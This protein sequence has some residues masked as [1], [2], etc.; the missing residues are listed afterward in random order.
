MSRMIIDTNI[1]YSL[2]GLSPN[3]KVIN[4]PIDQFKLSITTPSLIEVIS[5]YHNDLDSIKKCISPIINESI[6]LISIGHAPISNGFLYRL[7]FANKIDEVKDIIDN[8][9]T[10][11]ISREA[12]FYRFILI[13][14]VSGLFEV[15]RED[16]YKFDNNVQ[17]QS[18]LELVQTLLES[19]MEFILDFF[20]VELRDGYI[21]GNE[22]Q[23]ALNAF[24]TILIGL[25][26]GFHVN[27][28]MIKTDTVKIS[29]S[30]DSIKNLHD[31]LEND[32][33]DKKFKKYIDNPISLASKKKHKSAVDNYLK[34]MEKGLS[35]V[36]GLTE[37]SLSFLISK[38]E[39][40][41]KNGRKLRKN[42]IFDFL[43][44][45]SLNMPDA[46]ILTLDKGFLKDLEDL[47]PNSYKKCQDLGFLN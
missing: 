13:L 18:Q 26:N 28:H 38:V 24:E 1:L 3:Q 39:D 23:S 40:A 32:N 5:K 31:S 8:V 16:G 30:Q 4:S 47:H 46:L 17:N 25:L 44:V 2:V 34:E 10:L 43:I 14:V 11:K 19:N 35:G 9:R 36:F 27:Y 12:E 42:D 21:N 37:N 29:R 22:Q 20:K 41:Y 7:H 33:F 6:E 15:I 45:I